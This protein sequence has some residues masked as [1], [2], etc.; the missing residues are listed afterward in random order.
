MKFVPAVALLC[1]CVIPSSESD[2]I[3]VTE[4]YLA[5]NCDEW[6]CGMN[7]PN[8][9]SFGFHELNKQGI[10]NDEGFRITRFEKGGVDYALNVYKGR[11]SGKNATGTIRDNALVGA[12]IWIANGPTAA[13]VL[14]VAQVGEAPLWARNSKEWIWVQT[15]IL[16]WTTVDRGVPSIRW[17]NLCKDPIKDL[18]MQAY[19]SVLFEGDR[20]DENK[21]EIV[22]L[23]TSW[24]NI[25]CSG[26][27]LAKMYLT[28]HTHASQY[29]GFST[30][31]DERQTMLKMLSADFCGD[32]AAFTV[33]GT[34]LQWKDDH[35][36]M[37]YTAPVKLEARWTKGGASC[38]MSPRITDI[39]LLD[40]G[41]Y[42]T[43]DD[44]IKAHC[45]GVKP[46]ECPERPEMP[47]VDDVY[48]HHLNSAIPL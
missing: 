23:D 46:P 31:T 28:G 26:S 13:Y 15:Y 21:K 47:A 19:H 37:D 5:P 33:G 40:V 9:D 1:S 4:Q 41:E 29:Y 20:I 22:G 36:W 11:L 39:N 10:A 38:L 32:G 18:G 35:R 44:A 24:F 2:E 42:A 6:G 25:G 34:P 27:T 48:G 14:R 12:R 3:A 7:S 45:G 8:V 30:T 16:Q 43:V 17:A